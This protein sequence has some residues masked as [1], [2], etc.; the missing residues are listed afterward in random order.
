MEGKAPWSVDSEAA[1][2]GGYLLLL[3][4]GVQYNIMN[5]KE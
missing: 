1:E 4:G 5:K 2:K 3:T